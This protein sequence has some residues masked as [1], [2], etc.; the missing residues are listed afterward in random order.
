MYGMTIY[1]FQSVRK[2]DM[3]GFTFD[4]TAANLPTALAPWKFAGSTA[5]TTV[6][7]LVTAGIKRDGFY[8]TQSA[9]TSKAP[10][11]STHKPRWRADA[12]E[13]LQPAIANSGPS[14][15]DQVCP[16]FPANPT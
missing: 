5:R 12:L 13:D 3:F 15:D 11:P 16:D 2:I 14:I 4:S 9:P 8:L 10:Q 1:L 6:N 7:A